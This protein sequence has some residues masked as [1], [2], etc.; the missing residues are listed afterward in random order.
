MSVIAK[1]AGARWR[2]SHC[3][4]R[5]GEGARG[6]GGVTVNQI[7]AVSPRPLAPSPSR[8]LA[9]SPPRILT[10]ADTEKGH[11]EAIFAAGVAAEVP[12]VVPP[13]QPEIE[14]RAVVARELILIAGKRQLEA[15]GI[16]G[17]GQTWGS[18]KDKTETSD[19]AQH[20]NV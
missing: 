18:E 10:N 2:R 15:V 11:L 16:V 6:R 8:R 3:E 5:G 4:V 1:W 20:A 17:L 13:F 14:V 19:P 12:G 9:L 7:L